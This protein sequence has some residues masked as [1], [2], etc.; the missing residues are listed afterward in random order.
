VFVRSDHNS[1]LLVGL[2]DLVDSVSEAGF[3]EGEILLNG[4][5]PVFLGGGVHDFFETRVDDIDF[6]STLELVGFGI[7]AHDLEELGLRLFLVLLGHLSGGDVIEVLQPF[8]VGAGDTT[9]VDEHVRGNRDSTGTEFDLSSVSGGSVGTFED[10]FAVKR[11]HVTVVDGLLGGS[12][13]ETVT[14]LAHERERVLN[15][16]L[17]G[18]GE[19]VEGT[20]RDHV[21]F[22]SLDVETFG[23]VD[24]GVVLTD[25][26]D[27]GSF[28][29][30]ELGSPVADGTE[31][32]DDK[33]L[34]LASKSHAASV[35]ESLSVEELLN[36]VENTEPSGFSTSLDSSL[37]DELTSAASFGVDV[38]F[39]LNL[40]VG[41]LDPGHHLLVG[42]HV[43]S[44]AID[45][46]TDEVF[47]D[48]LHSV[49]SCY[50]LEFG[51][52][53]SLGVDLHSSLGSTEGDVSDSELESHE[54]SEGLNLLEIDMGRV[55]GSTFDGKFMGGV[56]GSV[57]GDDI[58]RTIIPTEG[59]VEADHRLASLD[60]VQVLLGDTGLGRG[61]GVEELD[62][63]EETG[64]TEFI[65]L[66]AELSTGCT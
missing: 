10:G 59:D 53:K 27:N 21:V 18:T 47:L 32:L 15:V 54:G 28:L 56:L 5:V 57:A 23:V 49:L 44:E 48:K 50:A 19:T 30:Q 12:G 4:E 17:G 58:E 3:S 39:S 52:R 20:V 43:G 51:G 24:G 46:G 64:F 8:E 41:I 7:V 11:I 16:L 55:S 6:I 22:D 65:K 13:D 33:G 38:L 62:L 45:G 61:S 25:S 60:Q 9:S 36:G 31:S 42:S 1:G 37:L 2:V 63:L 40:L 35:D 34:V 14:R 66:G 26:S 29:L